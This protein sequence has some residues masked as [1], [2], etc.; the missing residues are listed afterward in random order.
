MTRWKK[1]EKEF[2]VSLNNDKTGSLICRIPKPI[3]DMLGKPDGIKF[4]IQ[5]KRIVIVAGDKK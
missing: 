5:G 4:L 2:G 1:D 3:V